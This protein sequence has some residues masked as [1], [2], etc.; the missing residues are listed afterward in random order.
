MLSK[1][2]GSRLAVSCERG[3]WLHQCNSTR[4]SRRANPQIW[5]RIVHLSIKD[6][7]G[8]AVYREQTVE[9]AL[10]P[11]KAAFKDGGV[12]RL[13]RAVPADRVVSAL[14]E[15]ARQAKPPRP[16][17]EP[18]TL[19]VVETLRKALAWQ[20]DLDAGAVASRAELAR[21]EGITRARVTQVL[22]LLRLAPDIQEAVL[23]IKESLDPPGIGERAL[24]P[25]TRMENPRLQAA[26]FRRLLHGVGRDSS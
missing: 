4:T 21:R 17:P 19:P 25:I 5:F 8:C 24:R 11:K 23:A 12:G 7:S 18:R 10:G 2:E 20:R 9:V 3:D 6:S 26:A 13:T 15:R 1:A 16:P 22:M 14:S